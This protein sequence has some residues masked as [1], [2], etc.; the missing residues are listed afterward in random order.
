MAIASSY[1]DIIKDWEALE[2]AMQDNA[3]SLPADMESRRVAFVAQVAKVKELKARQ[4]SLTA[5]RQET[6][7]QL[8]KMI[9]EGVE[10]AR[11]LRAQAKASLGA[12]NERLVQ[13]GVAPLRKKAPRKLKAKAPEPQVPPSPVTK[14]SAA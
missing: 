10:M 4:D 7:Q 11:G 1:A 13:F 8:N 5:A 14:P 3:A 12:K 2:L 9:L 6:T